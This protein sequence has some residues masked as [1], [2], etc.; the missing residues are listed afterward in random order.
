MKC[1]P[2]LKVF[3]LAVCGIVLSCVLS[4]CGGG[5]AEAVPPA[6]K[7]TL[8]AVVVGPVSPQ[9]SVGAAQQFTATAN[10]SDGS[11]SEVT[12]STAWSSAATGI[13]TI[14]STGGATPGLAAGV[15][16]GTAMITATFGGQSANA[17]LAVGVTLQSVGVTPNDTTIQLDA[18][19]Q[20]TSTATYS[21][22]S[23]VN[24]TNLSR[25]SSSDPTIATIQTAGQNKPGLA[26]PVANGMANIQGA[27]GGITGLAILN[28][29]SS[30]G[31]L[32]S[33][34]LSEINPS[35][36]PG[37]TL[38]FTAQANYS[39][40]S[41]VDVTDTVTWTSSDPTKVAVQN[42]GQPNPGLVT[43]VAATGSS[44]VTITGTYNGFS[45]TATVTV[46]S[47]A[48]TVPLM[49]MTS[50]QNYLG[51]QGGLYENSSDTM[52]SAHST[53][54]IAAAAAIHPLNQ[55]G[56][57]SSSGAVVFLG[58]GMS[59]A[60]QEFS[61]F[62]TAA[63]GVDSSEVNQTTL[64]IEDGAYGDVTACPWTVAQ[65]LPT[66][67]PCPDLTGVPA[68]NQYDRVRDTV[69]A[70]AAGAPSA[71]AGC[72]TTSSPCLTE[73]QVQVL[74]LKDANPA[75]ALHGLGSLSSSTD[76][77][78]EMPTPT[79]EAC[80][81]EMQ[82]GQIVRAAKSRYP[83]LKQIFIST[84]I[85]AGY[86]DEPLNP[87]PYAYEYGFSGKWLIQAQIDQMNGAQADPVA[88]NLNY[89]DGPAAWTAWSAYL[90]ADGDIP[91]SDGLI[92]CDGQSSA[93][94]SGEIDFNTDGTHP[95]SVGVQKVV[96]LLMNFFTTSSYTPWFRP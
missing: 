6:I 42:M 76:C 34:G 51:F 36:A 11:T 14:Q 40:N 32:T 80:N 71:P 61:A 4:S 46:T 57:P 10:Y 59:N 20:F 72:G 23:G 56:N 55:S 15:A 18:T 81:Y 63:N 1:P 24:V 21:D 41:K 90:W 95:N 69:L 83:N 13:A 64:A 12:T 16:S 33:V 38:Q 35:I 47:S 30:G 92:W 22:K 88:G 9:I 82:M 19:Q 27:F 58:I 68:E 93:P 96:N 48:T 89:N 75:P 94:C 29:S 79:T 25:W 53:D 66:P 28:V 85:Y 54:G 73:A 26:T 50:S 3:C 8:T 5:T 39:D 7:P 2:Q 45:S 84:R 87:E 44:P 70:T 17:L 91:R 67:T 37:A 86:A 77:A 65:G 43:G 49:D 31:T 60:T 62:I 78:S 52:P 74:W